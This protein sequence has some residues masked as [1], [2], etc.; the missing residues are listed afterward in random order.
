MFPKD[1]EGDNPFALQLINLTQLSSSPNGPL[2]LSEDSEWQ[3]PCCIVYLCLL[4]YMFLFSLFV[5]VSEE[6]SGEW[7]SLE[8][9][10]KTKHCV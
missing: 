9:D 2:M 4:A 8:N 6:V 5:S 3:G 7:E 10:G 1:V